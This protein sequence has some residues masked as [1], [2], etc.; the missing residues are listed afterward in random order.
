MNRDIIYLAGKMSG[1]S[2]EEMCR[3]RNEFKLKFKNHCKQEGIHNPFN[4]V[5]PT[6]FYSFEEK[7]HKTEKEVMDYDLWLIKNSTLI[8]VNLDYPNSLGTAI[9]LYEGN[10]HCGIPVIGFGTTENHPWIEECVT[11]KFN[12]MNEVI[13]YIFEFYIPHIVGNY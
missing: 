5:S 13:N 3:W 1:L 6:D 8:V 2:V 7:K 10:K 11:V 4:I 12:T 9:E